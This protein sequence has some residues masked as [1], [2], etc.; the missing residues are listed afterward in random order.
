M[1]RIVIIFFLFS[2][3]LKAQ[4]KVFFKNGMMKKGVVVSIGQN[5]VFFKN[6]DTSLKTIQIP[7]TELLLIENYK[8]DISIFSD[9]K[10][11]TQEDNLKAPILKQ[12]IIG[13]QPF[14]VLF[15]RVT[16]V[17]E[18]LSKDNKV[19]FVFPLALTFDPMGSLYNSK[20][21]TNRNSV[22]RLSGVNFIV[23]LDVN[24][25]FGKKENSKFFIG[26]RIRY[27]TDMFLRGIEAYSLQTQFGWKIGRAENAFVQH[28]S[29]GYG[30]VRILSS[31]AG[32]LISSKQ[33]YSWFSVNYRVGI[34]W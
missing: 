26:P 8:G 7:K 33:S 13:T 16:L 31:P 3:T 11:N 30:F 18:R 28:L 34:K 6:S 24:F 21:D 10:K 20:I 5:A 1:K 32:S 15:G 25:Y 19:G 4:D 23:G 2:V 14:S 29:V 27:G 9:T 17:Y 22:K 12:N